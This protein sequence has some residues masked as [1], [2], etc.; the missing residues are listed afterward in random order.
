MDWVSVIMPIVIKLLGYA[1]PAVGSALGGPIGW[2]ASFL[3]TKVTS[4]LVKIAEEASKRK[5]ISVEMFQILVKA[6]DTAVEFFAYEEK[7]KSGEVV[8]DEEKESARL[9][10]EDTY[11]KLIQFNKPKKPETE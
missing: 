9:A 1:I 3:L 8:S 7:R 2:I 11:E 4:Y 5:A 6:N 10:L